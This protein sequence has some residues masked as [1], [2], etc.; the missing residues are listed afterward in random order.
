[1]FG[2]REAVFLVLVLSGMIVEVLLF[3][4]FL[5]SSHNYLLLVFLKAVGRS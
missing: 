3:F 2:K 5:R 1:M 4:F